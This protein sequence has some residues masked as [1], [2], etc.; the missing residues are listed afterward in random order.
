MF[1]IGHLGQVPAI[2]IAV[3]VGTLVGLGAVVPERPWRTA[4]IAEAPGLALAVAK[5]AR[6]SLG[7]VG[8]VVVM[9]PLV[10]VISVVLVGTGAALRRE[11]DE[12]R[13]RNAGKTAGGPGGDPGWARRDR[14]RG[15]FSEHGRALAVR[16]RRPACWPVSPSLDRVAGPLASAVGVGGLFYGLLFVWIVEGAPNWVPEVWHALLVVGG[17]LTIPVTVALYQ[18]VRATDE[19]LA[20]TA[21]FLGVAGA[22]GGVAHGAWN[23]AAIINIAQVG[24]DNASPDPGGILRYAAAGLALMLIGW[25]VVARP[26]RLPV[27]FGWLAVGSGVVLIYIYVGRLYDF[28]RPANKIS[29]WAPV[30]Y[31]LVLFP[32]LYL[33]LGRLLGPPRLHRPIADDST[34]R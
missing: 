23:L 18:M 9:S 21:L 17:L 34:M 1:L 4:A 6:D 15:A 27:P 24:R 31:G 13:T 25:L 5:A 20:L 14:S 19:G 11:H 29:L 22:L 28:V 3:T 10:L 8:L 2:A 32:A 12:H 33:W 16:T 26:G 7:L 30:L